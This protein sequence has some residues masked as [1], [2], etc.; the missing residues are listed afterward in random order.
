MK[1]PGAIVFSVPGEPVGKAR[2]RVTRSGHA[3]TPAKTVSYENL[4]KMRFDELFP[5]WV[6]LEKEIQVAIHAYYKIPKSASKAKRQAMLN[7]TINPTK[8]PDIDNVAKII[9]D[10]LN[11]LAYVD[12]TQIVKERIEKHYGEKPH[13][14]IYIYYDEGDFDE[15]GD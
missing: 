7:G 3:Y 10:A 11:G 5:D 14:D 2:P 15:G 1:F 12:D 4:V 8:K 13:V 6:P 9:N